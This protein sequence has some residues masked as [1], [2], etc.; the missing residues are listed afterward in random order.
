MGQVTVT[1]SR[2]S[3][4]MS[5][6]AI[7]VVQPVRLELL[8]FLLMSCHV[9]NCHRNDVPAYYDC[10]EQIDDPDQPADSH[11]NRDC[12]QLAEEQAAKASE[13]NGEMRDQGVYLERSNVE[14]SQGGEQIENLKRS[15]GPPGAEDSF[16]CCNLAIR[17]VVVGGFRGDW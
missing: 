2:L 11:C 14:C 9:R 10:V 7:T 13:L 16:E 12:D 6:A 8:L 15:E 4:S 5:L 3:L 17:Q 1:E